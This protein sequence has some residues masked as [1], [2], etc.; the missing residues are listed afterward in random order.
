MGQAR[1]QEYHLLGLPL[2]LA[3]GHQSQ[4]LFVLAE[5]RFDHRPAVVG[6]GQDHRLV[7]GQLIVP[8]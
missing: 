6:I 4:G 7:L 1:Q 5:G 3:A 8:N 2:A